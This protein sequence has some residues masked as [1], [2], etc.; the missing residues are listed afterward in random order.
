MKQAK[1]YPQK[2]EAL[3]QLIHTKVFTHKQTYPSDE[4]GEQ[5]PPSSEW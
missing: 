5:G 4:M 3:D 2:L 1:I